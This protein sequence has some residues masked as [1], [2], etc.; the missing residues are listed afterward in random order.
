M[1]K[2]TKKKQPSAKTMKYAQGGAMAALADALGNNSGTASGQDGQVAPRGNVVQRVQ[3]FNDP[4]IRI[5]RAGVFART[6]NFTIAGWRW[7]PSTIS[8]V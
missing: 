2:K 3:N 8:C 6:A 5:D 1:N 4:V 7:T